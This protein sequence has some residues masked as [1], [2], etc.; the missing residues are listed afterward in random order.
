MSSSVETLSEPARQTRSEAKSPGRRSWSL[1][2]AESAAGIIAST[3]GCWSRSSGSSSWA[4]VARATTTLPP[5]ASVASAQRKLPTCDIDEPGRKTSSPVSS[6]AIAALAIIQRSVS[7]EWVTPFA[8]PVEPEVKKMTA[9]SLGSGSALGRGSG[10]VSSRRWK[11]WAQP[12]SAAAGSSLPCGSGSDVAVGDR[13][14]LEPAGEGR[15]LDV[16]G[17]LDV[18]EQ[19]RGRR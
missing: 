12:G 5:T 1:I 10:G 4:S 7:R 17:A 19:H 15:G 16:R 8:G 6:K 18:G 13:P 11:S 14:Q 9:G 3:V 2:S